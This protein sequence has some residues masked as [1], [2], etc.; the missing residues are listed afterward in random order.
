MDW[1]LVGWL[2][3]DIFATIYMVGKPRKPIDAGDAM[4]VTAI[5][6]AL[7]AGILVTHG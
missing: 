2:V 6:A 1:T 7:I 5:C 3:L 4:L